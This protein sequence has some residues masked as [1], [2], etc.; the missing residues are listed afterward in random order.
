VANPVA[1][2]KI[3]LHDSLPAP[4]AYSVI[5]ASMHADSRLLTQN[6][7]RSAGFSMT[8]SMSQDDPLA[9]LRFMASFRSRR[10][11]FYWTW[12][13]WFSQHASAAVFS[14]P[15]VQVG[16]AMHLS[17]D[18]SSVP[19][20]HAAGIEVEIVQVVPESVPPDGQL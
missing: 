12:T 18:A 6:A 20:A 7:P 9:I 8:S 3:C 17:R 11:N 13:D 4:F 1:N 19:D 15:P 14:V 5:F 16:F 10:F 2:P